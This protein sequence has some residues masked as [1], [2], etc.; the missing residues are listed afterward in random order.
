MF[1]LWETE[2]NCW[3]KGNFFASDYHLYRECGYFQT[4]VSEHNAEAEAGGH[5]GNQKHR[6]AGAE[7]R[8]DLEQW[9]VN[10]GLDNDSSL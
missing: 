6:Q 8:G 1:P 7:L 4:S 3:H 5:L 2:K 10:V 9:R